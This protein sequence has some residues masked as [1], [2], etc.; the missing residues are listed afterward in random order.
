ME[1][2][3]EKI[4]KYKLAEVVSAKEKIPLEKLRKQAQSLLPSRN[5]FAALKAKNDKKETALICEIKKASPSK[6]IICADFDPIK[7]AKVYD[8]AGATAISVLTD[9][10]FFQGSITDLAKVRNASQLPILRKEF[11]VDAYQIYQTKIIGGD[12]ILLIMAMIDDSKAQELEAAAFECG[13]SILIEVHDEQELK[14]ALRLKSKLIGI[15][16]RD[17]KTFKVDLETSIRLSSAVPSDYILVAESGIKS[18]EDLRKLKQAGIN[19]FLIGEHFLS[20]K[21]I[22]TEVKKFNA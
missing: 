19:C 7:L 16:N 18:F 21:N 12:C 1:N 14:R 10:K 13:L 17:L 8:S 3:L 5:F 2:I 6:G 11:I 9:E 20:T 4:Y 22:E 15:N